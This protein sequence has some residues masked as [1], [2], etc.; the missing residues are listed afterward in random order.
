MFP[1]VA[2]ILILGMCVC[3]LSWQR[4]SADVINGMD[5][6]VGDYPGL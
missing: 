4:A 5:P 3:H 2:Y 1:R 6:E